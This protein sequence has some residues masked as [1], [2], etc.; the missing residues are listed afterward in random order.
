MTIFGPDV[1]SYQTGLDLSTVPDVSFVIA[2]TSE[3]TYYTDNA[4]QGFRSQAA[5]LSVPFVWYHLVTPE[6]TEAQVTHTLAC[7]GDPSLPGMI[8]CEPS[9]SRPGP[10]WQDIQDYAAAALATGLNLRLL[11][12]PYW[13]WQRIGSPD[14]TPLRE[15]GLVASNYTENGQYPGDTSARWDVP[16]D[17]LEPL[18]LQYTDNHPAGASFGAGLDFN[19]Y[20]GT[21][22]ELEAFLAPRQG[23]DMAVTFATG[24]VKPGAGVLTVVCPPPANTGANW[25]DVW[26]SLGSDFGNAEVRVAGYIHGEGWRVFDRV[27]VPAAGDR[28]N[29]FAGPAPAGLQKISILRLTGSEEVPLGWLVEARSR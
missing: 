9:G 6:A 27:E 11:Y 14:L 24:E 15:L 13:Y 1:S 29:P 25:A 4:Y 7:V 23:D 5:H 16:Y 2:K 20:R 21:P 8:D 3:G 17:G 22:T 10:S 12:L 28:V 19:A 26:F 18:I